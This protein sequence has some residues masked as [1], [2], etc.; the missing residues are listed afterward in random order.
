[1]PLSVIFVGVGRAEFKSM[2]HLCDS[3]NGEATRKNTTFVEFRQHQHDPTS[4]GRA[5]LRYMPSQLVQYMVQNGIQ[6]NR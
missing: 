2:Y 6:P 3:V 5:A 4:L 1:M